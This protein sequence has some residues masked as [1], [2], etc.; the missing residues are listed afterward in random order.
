MKLFG[1]KKLD[2]KSMLNKT[3]FITVQAK[4]QE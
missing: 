4:V 3:M 1:Y 2:L